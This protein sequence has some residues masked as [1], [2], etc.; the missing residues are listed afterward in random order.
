MQA[1]EP[2]AGAVNAPAIPIMPRRNGVTAARPRMNVDMVPPCAERHE[3]RRLSEAKKFGRVRACVSKMLEGC[4]RDAIG[5]PCGRH[6]SRP[7]ECQRQ[8][9]PGATCFK[10]ASMTWAL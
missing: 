10:I 2:A 6:I 3:F 7:R 5:P 9:R 4:H 8:P 1:G